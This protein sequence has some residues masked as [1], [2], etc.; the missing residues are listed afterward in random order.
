MRNLGLP[1][2]AIHV[3]LPPLNADLTPANNAKAMALLGEYADLFSTGPHNLRL[4][5]ETSHHL[6]LE[7]NQLFRSQSYKNYKVK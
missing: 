3:A 7:D 4:L 6:D 1:Y 2:P 5:K